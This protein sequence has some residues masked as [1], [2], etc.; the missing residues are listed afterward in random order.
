MTRIRS[1]SVKIPTTLPTEH[2]KALPW[3][4]R[5]MAAAASATV[6]VGGRIGHGVSSKSPTRVD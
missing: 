5:R 3:L 6:A 2:T 4:S 1:R